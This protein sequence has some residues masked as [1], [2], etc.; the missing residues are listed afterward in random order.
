MSKTI[1]DNRVVSVINAD[2]H[3]GHICKGCIQP[4]V[5]ETSRNRYQSRLQWFN[6]TPYIC[7]RHFMNNI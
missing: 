4:L 1:D 7:L 2:I 6:Q 3:I 5:C